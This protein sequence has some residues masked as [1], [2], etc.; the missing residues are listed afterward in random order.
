MAAQ[1][2]ITNS[3]FHV[4]FLNQSHHNHRALLWWCYRSLTFSEGLCVSGLTHFLCPLLLLSLGR[5]ACLPAILTASRLIP[6]H[7]ICSL[8]TVDHTHVLSELGGEES[9]LWDK[10]W[11]DLMW[12]Q[13]DTARK[14][15]VI[16][17]RFDLALNRWYLFG[18]EE[19]M[20]SCCWRFSLPLADEGFVLAFLSVLFI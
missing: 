2:K 9:F 16:T 5:K 12:S 14:Q 11:W 4:C 8:C 17:V 13:W 6:V 20:M 18:Q 10:C 3:H 19:E 1:L 15:V 7:W